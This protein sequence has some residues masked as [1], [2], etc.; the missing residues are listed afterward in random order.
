ML[1]CKQ[2]NINY[3]SFSRL[4]PKVMIQIAFTHPCTGAGQA[5]ITQSDGAGQNGSDRGIRNMLVL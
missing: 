4:N 3:S 1:E 5:V 2:I